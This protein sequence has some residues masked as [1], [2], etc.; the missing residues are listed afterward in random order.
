MSDSVP[1]L[2][3]R[4]STKLIVAVLA[5]LLLLTAAVLLV[6]DFNLHKVRAN[7]S[8]LSSAGLLAQGEDSLLRIT[9][10]EAELSNRLLHRAAIMTK[11]AADYMAESQAA[12]SLETVVQQYPELVWRTDQ[13]ARRED[14][15][16][17]DAN[18]ERRSD[19]YIPSLDRS[20]GETD[21]ILRESAA[22]DLLF[23]A[24]LAQSPD[25]VSIF[26]QDTVQRIMRHYPALGAEEAT[27]LEGTPSQQWLAEHAFDW[28][29]LPEQN[30]ERATRW[31]PPYRDFTGQGLLIS[32]RTPVYFGDDYRGF[33]GIDVSLARL[34]ERLRNLR[35]TPNAF[36]FLIN[37]EGQLIAAPSE[38]VESLLGVRV[39]DEDTANGNELGRS[40]LQSEHTELR[41]IVAQMQAGENGSAPVELGDEPVVIAFAPLPDVGWS[42][43]VVAPTNDIVAD[44]A[45]VAA[46]IE[47]D[48]ENTVRATLLT[49]AVF[50]LVAMVAAVFV[51]R[52]LTRPVSSLVAGTQ[53]IMG[54]DLSVRL[55][56]TS[57]DEFGLLAS[58][59]NEMTGELRDAYQNLEKRVAARTRELTTL[60]EISRNVAM[61]M[62][63]EPLLELILDQLKIVI[64]YAGASILVLDGDDYV[65]RAYR[66]PAP[67]EATVQ[68]RLS[69]D[70]YYSQLMLATL[71]PAIIDDV[72][73]ETPEARLAAAR[74]YY[75]TTLRYV[76][77]YLGA[78]LIVRERMIGIL[79]L[80]H[81]EPGH[82]NAD[83]GELVM[84]FANQAAVAIQNA[85]LFDTV[86]RR[87]D[88]FRAISELGQ[89]I[90]SIL[91]ID[92]LLTQA[93]HLIQDAFGYYHVHIGLIEG[94]TVTL[95]A[96]AGVWEDEPTC[97]Y[98][99][100]LDLRLEQEAICSIVVSTGRAF[101]VPDISREPRYPHPKRATGSG[102]VVPL[103]VKGQVIGLLDVESKQV[104][105]FDESDVAVLQL[106]ANQVAVAIENARLYE[107]A[108]S[109][110][111][112][113][114]SLTRI[115]ELEPLLGLILDQL[116]AVVDYTGAS[117][118]TLE[119]EVLVVQE[120]RGPSL[121]EVRRQHQ[122]S[123]YS[124]IDQVI[125]FKRQPV[126]IADI[127]DD[128]P[129]AR[130]FRETAGKRLDTYPH[131]RSWMG[132]PLVARERVVGMLAFDH[133]VPDFY[134]PRHVELATA[135]A[136]QAALTIENA[137]LFHTV[138]RRAEQFRV[139]AELGRGITSILAV[140][141]LLVQTARSIRDSFG[142]YH[143]HIGF[144]E[145]D[146]VIYKTGAAYDDPQFQ[147]CE[148]TRLK[149]GQEGFVGWVAATGEPLLVPD[150]A[151]DPRNVAIEGDP[152]RSEL[153]LP[154]K[155]KGLVI[156]VLDIESDQL[157]AFDELD[158]AVLQSLASQVAVAIEN[159]RLYREAGQ[160]AALQERQRLA[161]ELHDSVSQALYGIA[162]GT[163]T[164]VSLL[165]Q[166]GMEAE[167][168][169]AL[170]EPLNYVMSLAEAGLA[171][172]RALIFELRPES[173][174]ME[175]LV[176]ALTR[177][178]DALQARHGIG[179]ITRF[180]DEPDVPLPVKE[181]L[182][183]VAQET[184]HNVVKHAQASRVEVGLVIDGATV[185]LEVK[186]NGRGFDTQL[187]FPGH[188]G[189]RSM[190]E[191]VEGISGTFY[192]DSKPGQGT[193]I[194][195][196]VTQELSSIPR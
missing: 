54:G 13:L 38:K 173:L 148:S 127:R 121:N 29:I 75:K 33:I 164:A 132:V 188:L 103:K 151:Q 98:C 168:T 41:A 4:L 189:L 178:A 119:G 43:G 152:T 122:F 108:Q 32:A 48:I 107:Q 42:L 194:R 154:L 109:L 185:I 96:A 126:I 125:V 24:L 39:A 51:G 133:A 74:E 45:A 3:S 53:A 60:L 50:S 30:P 19:I 114:R 106:L 27:L 72:Q 147:L 70:E 20:D 150:S 99:T 175:G 25:T 190:R 65:V 55:P 40:L 76:R 1:A 47:R 186:D 46:E 139:V 94:D 8:A 101:T 95:P 88:Q 184:L 105:A 159:A 49:I 37:R 59:F 179:V 181:A 104:N 166:G 177:Q 57:R 193:C 85:R 90:T 28:L 79:N 66:G 71:Q 23:P 2:R 6:V 162:L 169:T 167:Q 137:R 141:E 149:V 157:N 11:I 34:E 145:G 58:S 111:E 128:T 35:P 10:R 52:S 158:V 14:G 73:A 67:R 144:I 16:F 93:V 92:E 80:H 170:R 153:V 68:I 182:Y 18:P 138:Q 140:D 120:R 165:A 64:D 56:V 89:R 142:Y 124:E 171:E 31:S 146:K 195:A 102:A 21:R 156:G 123:V 163:R 17:Y 129:L 187:S 9:V 112:V 192:M 36:G 77:S 160:V 155:I 61:T 63:L 191:R 5:F 131:I 143:V 176:A 87:A 118:L 134:T 26:Y 81:S 180:G 172:M 174:A 130:T 86:Q 22:L 183:R 91:D 113:S 7:A 83:H 12:N 161:R 44:A 84:A 97:S 117:V 135:F 69:A 110:L 115:L 78:P 116:K 100:T 196:E 15:T 136:N 82:F 62:D